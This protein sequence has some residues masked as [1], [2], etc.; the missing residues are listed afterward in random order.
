MYY[1]V[2]L[3][4]I[5][6]PC[7]LIVGGIYRNDAHFPM[8]INDFDQILESTRQQCVILGDFNINI[9]SDNNDTVHRCGL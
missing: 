1:C 9:N 6:T 7:K 3:V 4:E 8:F 5:Q 2:L